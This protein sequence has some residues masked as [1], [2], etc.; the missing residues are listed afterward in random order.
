LIIFGIF[1]LIAIIPIVIS[2]Y[3][4]IQSRIKLIR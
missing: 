3:S 4:E 2:I 1:N